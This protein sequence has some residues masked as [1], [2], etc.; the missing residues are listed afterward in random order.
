M[1]VDEFTRLADAWGGDVERWPEATRLAAQTLASTPEGAAIL[2]AA[3]ELDEA[4]AHLAPDIA[5][6]RV[7]RAMFAVINTI[8]MPAAAKP[9]RRRWFATPGLTWLVPATGFACAAF[10]GVSLATR[11]PV[12]LTHRPADAAA[13]MAVLIDT[14][15]QDQEFMSQ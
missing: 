1:T 13:L 15:T 8:A 11:L 5:D 2:K 12:D 9:P 4:I 14:A 3:S 10:L 6:E 7:G